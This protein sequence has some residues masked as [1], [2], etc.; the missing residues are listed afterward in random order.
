MNWVKHLIR[1]GVDVS[2]HGKFMPKVG[3][4]EYGVL[5]SEERVISA[6]EW[7]K[8]RIGIIETTPF[9]F[10]LIDN[11]VKIANTMIESDQIGS[12][13]VNAC[14]RMDYILVPNEFQKQAFEKSGIKKPVIVIPHGTETEKFPFYERPER[15][16]FTFGI[17]GYLNERKGVF[18]VIRAFASEFEP[19]EPVRL[20]LKTSNMAF[21]YYRYFHD[22]RITTIK[23][24]LP[25]GGINDLYRSFDCFV[26]PSRAEG[27]GQPPR[28][29][30]AT[31]LPVIATKY[32]GLEEICDPEISYPLL[33]VR[34]EVGVNP[35][36]IE[37]PGRWAKIDIREL[38]YQMRYVYEH[39]EES[40]QKGKKAAQWIRNNFSWE[41]CA[42]KMK[43]FLLT[44]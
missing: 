37:Q 15:D 20:V 25:L 42:A 21:G 39:K 29:A 40:R 7:A 22:T 9:D 3:S 35:Q 12:T 41:R 17:V 26:F 18:D 19:D 33:P 28:E 27:V 2:P 44:L 14:S 13:W 31:G 4:P 30:M 10:G 11:E 38:M 24:L 5:D 36:N 1:Q 43:E 32:S 23:S 34:Y 8:H 6:R 16:I